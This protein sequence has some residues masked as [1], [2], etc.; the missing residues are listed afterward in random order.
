MDIAQSAV[1]LQFVIVYP[2]YFIVFSR[3]AAKHI[4]HSKH[5]L[6]HSRYAG[7]TLKIK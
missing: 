5:V 3:Y 6:T 4:N 2:A 1:K 7:V